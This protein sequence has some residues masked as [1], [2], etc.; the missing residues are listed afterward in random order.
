MS[1][2][3]NAENRCAIFKG[4]IDKYKSV[5]N[6]LPNA[7]IFASSIFLALFSYIA[8]SCT[9]S[10]I[11]EHPSVQFSLFSFAQKYRR[12]IR[13]LFKMICT[14]IVRCANFVQRFSISCISPDSTLSKNRS[15]VLAALSVSLGS[16]VVG[17]SSGYTS[18]AIPSMKDPHYKTFSMSIEEVSQ[19]GS[20]KSD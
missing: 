7:P 10:I 15:Q 19:L 2:V 13:L 18:P 14:H 12:D 5:G 11:H 6:K 9:C 3:C 17:F 1:S 16:L 4:R 8:S 20:G